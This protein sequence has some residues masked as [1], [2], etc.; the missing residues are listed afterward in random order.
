M[1]VCNEITMQERIYLGATYNLWLV[2]ITSGEWGSLT[3]SLS[4]LFTEPC[5]YIYMHSDSLSIDEE[6]LSFTFYDGVKLT[7]N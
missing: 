1:R 2:L 4:Y 7:G 5:T 3:I 6:T